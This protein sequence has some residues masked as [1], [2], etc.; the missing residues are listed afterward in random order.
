VATLLSSFIGGVALL[1]V[2]SGAATAE[3][4]SGMGEAVI[5]SLPEG[6]E[7]DWQKEGERVRT[8]EFVSR[9]QTVN[10]WTRLVT[11]QAHKVDRSPLE[12]ARALAARF[13]ETCPSTEVYRDPQPDVDGRPAVRL[14]LRVSE[15]AGGTAESDLVLVIQGR[16]QLFV[17]LYAWRPV[18]PT[19]QEFEQ[20]NAVLNSVRVCPTPTGD[21][22]KPE[23]WQRLAKT[24]YTPQK[25]LWDRSMAAAQTAFNANR[26]EEADRLYQDALVEAHRLDPEHEAAVVATYGALAQL[27][28]VQRREELA[29]EMDRRAT[30]IRAKQDQPSRRGERPPP[31]WR[32]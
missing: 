16:A 17:V 27:Y 4:T 21:C 8:Q 13:K 9:P 2:G 15:C 26:H 30:V 22:T 19:R 32:Q 1:A 6:W 12:F 24:R 25:A 3:P 20:A 11:V 23:E 7:L 29:A 14:F 5:L 18:P 28:R 31:A 10:N